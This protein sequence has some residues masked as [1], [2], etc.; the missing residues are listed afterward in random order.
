[1]K[2]TPVRTVVA[3]LAMSLTIPLVG[4]MPAVAADDG[5]VLHYALDES[6][7]TTAVDSSGNG[8][9][10]AYVG[11]VTLAGSEG[12]ALDGVNG[13]VTLPNDILSGLDSITVSTEVL[14]KP[15]Q[16]TPY[17]IFG[18]GN[19][20]TSGSGTGYLFVTGNAYK[21]AITTGNWSGEQSLTSGA[22][23]ERGVWKTLTYTLDDATDTATIYLDGAVVATKTGVTITPAALGGGTTTSNYIG[24]SNYATDR[25]LSGSVRD[26]R[27]YD[28]ALDAT[29]VAA[30]HPSDATRAARDAAA[31][32]LG[33]LSAVTANLT[34]PATGVN[35]SAI[36]WSSDT[37]AVVSNS[38]AVTR[39]AAGSGDA[40]VTLTATITRGAASD[41]KPFTVTVPALRDDQSDVE[42]AAGELVV[43]GLDD[44]RGNI[45]LPGAP[46]GMSI[47]WKTS[48]PGIIA[49]DGIVTRP[50]VDTEVTV[51][52]RLTKNAAET[53]RDFTATVRAAVEDTEYEG[54]AF[55]YFTGNS[56]E[57]ENIYFAASEGN[58]ALQ[59]RELNGGQPTLRSTE[60]TK[61]LRDPFLIRSP[62]GDTFY[63]IATD[64]SIGGGTSWGESVRQGSHYIEVWESHDLVNWSEQR[65]LKV[66]PDNAGNTWAPEAYYDE[67]IGAYVVF[68]AS[69]LYADD[70]P[71][72]VGNSYHRM[73]YVTTRDFVT[74][75]EPEIWQDQ[76][77]SRID[78]TVLEVDGTYHRFTKDEGAGGTG[79]SDIIQ[80]KSTDL[81]AT[82]DSWSMVTSCIGRDAGTSAVEGPTVFPA[83]PG[84][85][86]GEK[87]YLFVD[88]YGGR[89]YI[90]LETEDIEN[91]D[92]TVSA[93]YDL[94]ASP[95][96][97][98]V[99]P[100]TAAELEA[101]VE[102]EPTGPQ[103]APV[104]E[105]GELLRY[106]FD[107]GSG[108][109]VADVSGNGQD[110]AIV[111]GATWQ[112]G[113]LRLDG[114]TGYVDLPDNLLAGLDDI[115]IEA[116]VWIDSAQTGA[117]FIYGLGNTVSGAGNGYLFTTGNAY[118]TSL[119]TG[120]W[121]TEQ[122]VSQGSNLARGRWAHLTYTLEGTTATIYLDGVAVATS[123]VTTNPGDIGGGT[124]TANYL[125]RSN[126]DADNR[127]RG[128]FREFA[129]F[130]RAL[131][132]AEVLESS[133]NTQALADVSLA[134][135]VLKTA[136]IVDASTREIVFPVERG[137]D[138]TALTPVYTT[139]SAV[140]ATPASGTTRDLSAPVEVSLASA[141]GDPV[142][143]T[144]RAVVMGSPTIPGLY[145]DPNIVAYGDTYYVYATSDGYPGWG[146]KDFYVWSSKNLVDWERA[147][148][149]FLTLDGSN[150]N[151]PWAT[152]NAWAP[153][154]AEKDGKYYFYFSGHN[155]TYDRKT[156][157]VAV[158]DHP[159]GPFT[160]DPTAMILNN[161]SVTSGQAIDP[162][163]FVDPKTGKHYLF[164]GNGSP[165][166]AELSDDMR[167]IKQDTLRRIN[168]LTDFREGLF[169]NYRDG[170]YHLTY[171]IDDTGSTNYRVGYATSTSVDGPWTYRGVILEKDTSLGILAT[172]HS[173]ILNVPGTDD[174]YI[175]YH[176]FAIPGG[177]GQHRETTIDRVTFNE[178]TGLMN[179]V[180][181]T[182][183]SVSPQTIVDDEPLAA[184][185]SGTAREGETLTAA[186]S[187]PW[188]A[189]GF[190]WSRDD[191]VIE[192]AT[193]STY[194]LTAADV[195]ATISVEV[196]ASK[197]LWSDATDT[198]AVGPVLP[199]EGDV[200]PTVAITIDGPAENA[201]GWRNGPVTVSL[202]LTGGDDDAAEY[203]LD[204]GEWVAYGEPVTLS[205]DGSTLVEYRATR[206]GDA[207]EGTR[208]SATVRIDAIAP[209]STIA[210]SPEDG[211]GSAEE[212]VTVTATATDATSGVATIE[213]RLRDG[214][215]AAFPADGLAFTE[216]GATVVSYRSTDLAGNVETARSV[217]VTI[218]A[219]GTVGTLEL[220]STTLTAGESFTVRGSG[221]G[222][223]E[224][225][226][227]TLFSTP[228]HLGGV[229]TDASGSFTATLLVPASVAAGEHTLRAAG[230]DSG[231]TAEVDVTVVA[232]PAAP[233]SGG[234][235]DPLANT[236][237][238]IGGF[239][240]AA[241]ILLLAGAF[242]VLR[243]RRRESTETRA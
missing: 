37:P 116:D 24:R 197:P 199:A 165:V 169:L 75:T 81:R 132:S 30:L 78:S 89:G 177:D 142:V 5:L 58:N 188:E 53:T 101:L 147:A 13:H 198:A 59:W 180:T 224:R 143:W 153:T 85:V 11:G 44:V 42:A 88:E 159:E 96:H 223:D 65:H 146:G 51:T 80:E 29:A 155:P 100:V 221:F 82:L 211:L 31:L 166:Y 106:S 121:T 125:G 43:N 141:T 35:G 233:G 55:A 236:G 158:A 204:E 190:V 193:A 73:M 149:P 97:G 232:A 220:E 209:V 194:A 4:A 144:L 122:T 38:G 108:S 64:L 17:F 84:D 240:T 91:P 77:L 18:L 74:F 9:D 26:F 16:A 216:V 103:P 214:E 127:F 226:E 6:S 83:N 150:G 45:T 185:L 227:F 68:W 95:R 129:I 47:E 117:Y 217:V 69:S 151:V 175:A 206:G 210:L 242:L 163:T 28:S 3:A 1:M 40:V 139:S 12:V 178:Q 173:S 156:I 138:L 107:G 133:G 98:T 131:S 76:G 195:G 57:G 19:P 243:R 213:Y 164:W 196:S 192:G 110:G 152:G 140:T 102:N 112:D 207:V 71:G 182:L 157:G 70:D 120:N 50:A 218:A 176:R 145:A 118:R 33:D 170:L 168:G 62:E 202:T 241:G 238:A 92:W 162:A 66:A 191:S 56:L 115:T 63:L 113:A 15:T 119:A 148:E 109:T 22:N 10:G 187:E 20:A 104:N 87:F 21:A 14:I 61:G 136:P 200:D 172:G 186:A 130:N 49:S 219:D 239:V 234:P 229:Q 34:L 126:Y 160:A 48:E 79:C 27:I 183:E 60:G 154:I 2:P 225:V 32:G 86:N 46:E 181:P 124:T 94:P 36:T 203:R 41:S 171:S 230:A 8:H 179:P 184:S 135:D 161:E 93:N 137:T 39:P 90:P 212:P 105:A 189:T 114:A 99:I 222:A 201:A 235:G 205:E 23:V 208:G 128:Q 237:I 72:H 67:S 174:W 54:Y 123:T 167:S 215:W 231:I 7:G 52:A 111:G 25:Y 228:T 134:E